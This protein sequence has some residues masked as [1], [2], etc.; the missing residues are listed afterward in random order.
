M[1]NATETLLKLIGDVRAAHDERQADS[2]LRFASGY[3]RALSDFGIIS[4]EQDREARKSLKEVRN[5]WMP[6]PVASR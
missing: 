6:R 4:D 3:V 1:Q 5:A 2:A